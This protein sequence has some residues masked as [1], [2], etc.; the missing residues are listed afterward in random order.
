MSK[1]KIKAVGQVAETTEESTEDNYPVGYARAILNALQ[2]KHVYLGTVS[3]SVVAKRRAKNKRARNAR[4][5][6]R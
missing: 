3:E 5:A 4:K 6:G 2:S 1:V